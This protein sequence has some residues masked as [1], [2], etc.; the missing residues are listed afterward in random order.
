MSAESDKLIGTKLS[1]FMNHASICRT[2]E[3]AFVLDATPF[4]AVFKN[5]LS[6]DIG[7]ENLEGVRVRMTDDPIRY[8]LRIISIATSTSVRCY[9]RKSF[10]SFKTSLELSFSKTM[11]SHM[12]QKLFETSVLPMAC[13]FFL[14]LLICRIFRLLSTCGIWL[15]GVS[16][17]IRVKQFHK[18]NLAACTSNVEFSSTSRLSKSI[19]FHATSYSSTYC[20]ECWLHQ[21]LILDSYFFLNFFLCKFFH[22]IVPIQIVCAL[23]FI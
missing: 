16:L 14:G 18:T 3:G 6:K 11:H 5:V 15:F 19:W 7:V 22:L 10:S 1:F 23:N 9:S 17:V 8:E 20:R 4:N 2:M 21:I 13:D 12:L